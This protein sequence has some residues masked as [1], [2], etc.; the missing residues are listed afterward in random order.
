MKRTIIS[1]VL[2]AALVGI[3]DVNAAEVEPKLPGYVVV[4][5]EVTD[6]AGY[7]DYLKASAELRQSLQGG[8]FLV[9]GATGTSL[10][11]EPPKTI[12]IIRFSSVDE[13]IAYYESPQYSAIKERRD[14]ALNWRS[15]VVEGLGE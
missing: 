9:R 8:T 4:E 2:A 3:L 7:R 14:K 11:G 13:A 15:F 5:Y 10:S 12:A 6:P 1:V